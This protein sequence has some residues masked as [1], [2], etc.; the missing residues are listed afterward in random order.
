M[1][2]AVVV[3]IISSSLIAKEKGSVD[4]KEFFF[5]GQTEEA[6]DLKTEQIGTKYK[7]EEIDST[8]TKE[9]PYQEEVCGNVTKYR[10]EEYDATCS[11]QVPHTEE[12]CGYETKYRTETYADTCY[13]D[14]AA[15]FIK[16][17]TPVNFIA[18]NDYVV[19]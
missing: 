12:V 4:F 1:L 17:D 5:K 6:F 8:C 11:K 18:H 13:R 16:H 7:D 14:V 15:M 10:T 9:V 19:G 2:A 3:A